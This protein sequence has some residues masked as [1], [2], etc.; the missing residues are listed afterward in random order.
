MAQ[1]FTLVPT[2]LL[3]KIRAARTTDE[4]DFNT[5]QKQRKQN[6]PSL[7]STGNGTDEVSDHGAETDELN[8]MD[9]LPLLLPKRQQ[10]KAAAI[11]HF[12]KSVVNMDSNNRIIYEDGSVGSHLLDLLRYYT[13][14]ISIM[15]DRPLDALKFG[16]LL[17]KAGVP[18][19]AIGR[20]LVLKRKADAGKPVS[21]AKRVKNG[22]GQRSTTKFKWKTI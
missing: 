12:L 5:D 10:N 20:Q 9:K 14:P 13:S 2:A 21:V 3:E 8:R 16:L 11:I 4:P 22:N 17:R 7:G 19:Y 6:S 15:K 18:E 1:K